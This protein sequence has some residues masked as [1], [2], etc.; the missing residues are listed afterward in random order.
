MS[1]STGGHKGQKDPD[2]QKEEGP[3]VLVIKKKDKERIIY[4]RKSRIM[5]SSR[6]PVTGGIPI[7]E[8]EAIVMSSPKGEW[9]R[10]GLVFRDSDQELGYGLKAPRNGTRGLLSVVQ[11]HIVKHLLFEKRGKDQHPRPDMMLKPSRARQTEALW[12]AISDILWRIG[13]KS[14]CYVVMPQEIIHIPQGH[15]YLQD[16]VT[17]KLNIFEFTDL[18]DLQIFI[19][20][21]LFLGV[22]VR[23]DLDD[24]KGFLVTGIEE[25]SHCIVTL[26]LTGRATPYLHNG[27]VYVG[28]EDHYA[29]PQFGILTRSEVG[30]LVWDEC[31]DT[32]VEESRQPGSRLKTPS[33]PVW[34]SSCAGHYGVLFNTNREL[35]RNYHAERRFDLHYYTCGGSHSLLSIDTRY[36]EDGSAIGKESG[37]DDYGT[38]C[39]LEKL[40]HTK[41]QDA[42]VHWSGPAPVA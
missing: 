8:E 3:N 23:T 12:T 7:T 35:L 38:A 42:Y 28:D 30:F 20:R 32:K 40:V 33:L 36:N 25:G 24:E 9:L 37:R 6:N 4:P 2:N 10:T 16:G 14:K 22:I 31:T 13:E 1:T 21:Y 27:V 19:K 34:V 5:S 18:E 41:W 11:A 26:L 15:K 29:M 17:E 39:P